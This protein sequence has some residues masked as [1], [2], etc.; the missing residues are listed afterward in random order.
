M[1]SNNIM[2][3]MQNKLAL[4]Q[5]N[6]EKRAEGKISYNIDQVFT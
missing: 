5:N 4:Q 1:Y 6:A 3:L 2:R